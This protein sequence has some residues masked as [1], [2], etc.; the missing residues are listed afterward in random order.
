MSKVCS[1]CK[2]LKENKDFFRWKKSADGYFCWCKKCQKTACKKSVQKLRDKLKEYKSLHPC[3][4]CGENDTDVLIL[5]H[6]KPGLK[7]FLVSEIV[8][9]AL[10]S[11]KRVLAELNKCDSLCSNCHRKLHYPDQTRKI[12]MRK[13][14]KGD[15]VWSHSRMKKWE[16][17]LKEGKSC[18][19]CGE[20]H[21]QCLE[22][23]H[24]NPAEKKFGIKEGLRKGRGKERI[25]LEI[26][27][28]DLL[29]SNC[30]MRQQAKERREKA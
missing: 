20:T 13:N 17:E 21:H 10:Y 15:K 7:E 23:H 28:C 4:I 18:I 24:R 30:H 22:F 5:H 1:K 2:Q 16:F 19:I 9:Q 29:C 3:V 8:C 26:N 11:W 6:R 14:A 27:K 25:L 12:V